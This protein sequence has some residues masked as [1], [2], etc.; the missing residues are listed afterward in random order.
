MTI[1]KLMLLSLMLVFS[2][3]TNAQSITKE[4]A[5]K[6]C[7][8]NPYLNTNS[9]LLSCVRREIESDKEIS[10]LISSNDSVANQALD[11]CKE[12]SYLNTNSL[13]LSCMRKE[14]EAY[15]QLYGNN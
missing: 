12:N 1:C 3:T 7:K 14:I 9:L 10:D 5:L 4:E 2:S 8:N 13:L 6:I 11:T 15:E